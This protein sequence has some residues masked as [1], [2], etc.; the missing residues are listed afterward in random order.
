[1]NDQ[2]S[3]S[4]KKVI[5]LIVVIMAILGLSA[6]GWYLFSYI[7]KQ[8]A[9]EKARLELIK[10][11]QAEKKRQQQLA[12]KRN[13]YKK[14][15]EAADQRFAEEDWPAAQ[16]GYSRASVL[17]PEE[18]YPKSQLDIVGGKLQEIADKEARKVAG[19]VE[20]LEEP[21]GL[22]YVIISS[23]LD[24]D[25]AMD[26]AR[27][28]L[29][30]DG[31]ETKIIPHQADKLGYY[32]VAVEEFNARTEAAAATQSYLEKFGNAWVLKY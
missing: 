16:S 2:A 10:K 7:P 12:Q 22:Y 18:S 32:G 25:L 17:F 6:G 26:Y 14:L 24:D 8:E 28:L 4:S 9:K 27:K 1:M 29:L 19:E 11:Q 21:T 20:V 5:V 3:G 31:V 23:S 15:I 30:Q 13:N